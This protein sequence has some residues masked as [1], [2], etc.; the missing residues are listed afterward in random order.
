MTLGQL[1]TFAAIA[2]HGSLTAA[3]R[4]LG[5][6]VPAVSAA[7]ATLRRELGDE[8]VTRTP[9]GVAL[10]TGGSRL[11]AA[12][13]ELLGIAENARRAVREAHDG[14]SVLRVAATHEI[15][16]YAAGPLVEAFTRTR[17]SLEVNVTAAA[18]AAFA[19]LLRDRRADIALGPPVHGDPGIE[20][21]AFLRAQ[22][23]VVASPGHALARTDTV[24]LAALRRSH[25]LSGPSQTDSSTA[26]AQLVIRARAGD[27][28]VAFPSQAAA[29]AAVASG[30][31]VAPALVHTVAE[32][33]RRGAL[34]RL[35]VPGTP[36]EQLWHAST[37]GPGLHPH[38]AAMLRRF[39]TT[40]EATHAI[41]SRSGGT[42]AK[43]FRPPVYITIWN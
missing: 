19:G 30:Q 34:V 23:I 33:L 28:V 27:D 26:L 32:E 3:A 21:V 25:W 9:T 16:E 17:P 14:S 4:E 15:A 18:G 22:T 6:S 5:V 40:P 42:N 39:I 11:A 24:D 43:R 1:Q 31:G 35:D 41:L 13:A 12:A 8:L 29:L 2:R 38:V 36:R 7:L 37:L 10:T 20:S